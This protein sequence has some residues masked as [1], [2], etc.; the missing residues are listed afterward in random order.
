[1]DY[2]YYWVVVWIWII[3]AEIEVFG[4]YVGWR[5][6]R[7]EFVRSSHILSLC[8]DGIDE[9]KCQDMQLTY[10]HSNGKILIP[11]DLILT[12]SGS[13]L[14]HRSSI[15]S[16]PVLIRENGN[17]AE[18]NVTFNKLESEV[19]NYSLSY[20]CSGSEQIFD[21]FPILYFISQI[22]THRKLLPP[23]SSVKIRSSI[24]ETEKELEK[25]KRFQESLNEEMKDRRTEVVN[26]MTE[27]EEV[28]F[29]LPRRWI[30]SHNLLHK[31]IGA[32]LFQTQ[33]SHNNQ[34]IEQNNL[35][36]LKIFVHQR[37]STKRL[38]PSMWDMFIGGVSAFN[39]SSSQTLFRE[40]LEECNLNLS[41]VDGN[42]QF[43]GVNPSLLEHSNL[44][45][46]LE[47]QRMYDLLTG[48]ERKILKR[49]RKFQNQMRWRLAKN[50]SADGIND[51]PSLSNHSLSI[52]T[53]PTI[54]Q[55]QTKIHFLRTTTIHTD[56]N[57]CIVDCFA[58]FLS[59]SLANE[60]SF[61]DKEI[62][63]GE[64]FSWGRLLQDL[65]SR[66]SDYVPDGLQVS[67]A[68][69]LFNA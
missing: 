34:L 68:T 40:L 43:P 50:E 22:L 62:D 49:Q 26:W 17:S 66:R 67:L 11:T 33:P 44:T 14:F 5:L 24:L 42:I 21:N 6:K 7:K 59:S 64:W 52:Q 29:P 56:Y 47:Q 48:K 4:F 41:R 16:F 12:Y 36:D 31:G 28:L 30:H 51:A 13:N 57:H 32:L 63:R 69:I 9:Y 45:D 60:I 3:L 46:P 25:I 39:E 58:V 23:L 18:I 65:Q 20:D 8:K 53:E 35:N 2:Y 10:F 55:D 61:P 54:L 1:M 15:V 19:D 38:F 27:E 37:S